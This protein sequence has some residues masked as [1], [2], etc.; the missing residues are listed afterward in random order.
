MVNLASWLALAAWGAGA[1]VVVV[2]GQ[3]LH[4]LAVKSGRLRFFGTATDTGT[5]D[6]LEYTA[7][8]NATGEFGIVVPENSM[9]WA[10]TE[11]RQGQFTLADADAV[12][13]NA[14]ANGQML[15]C[16]TLTWHSQLPEFV[17][18]GSW[19]RETL[20]AVIETHISHV[21]GH[22]KGACYS[23]DVVNEALADDGSLRDSVFSRVLGRDF[24][25]LSFRAAAA[26]DPGA[27]LYYND[28]GLE[29]GSA[30]TDGAAGI[31]RDLRAAGAR[32]DGLGF[33]AHLEVG[34]APPRRLLSAVL[35]RF[36]GMGLEVAL[37]ELDIRH[38]RVPADNDALQQQA[39]DYAGVVQACVDVDGCVG[40][41]V[42]QFTDKYSW[43]PGTF[44]GT[45]DACLYDDAMRP[46]PAYAAVA[47]VLKKAVAAAEAA[48][49]AAA[50]G[51]ANNMTKAASPP[52][53]GAQ[54]GTGADGGVSAAAVSQPPSASGAAPIGPLSGIRS[55]AAALLAS[56]A[57]AA[58]LAL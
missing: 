57:L 38:A 6:D 21:V 25:A 33:Q 20:S 27:K 41:V 44:P 9:K 43:V 15:R 55:G 37:T 31:A 34:R 17:S 23:W 4:E 14:K 53:G 48:A 3:G 42:W 56:W 8:L 19:T 39:R 29:F 49:A 7:V 51:N 46:K 16:H 58:W 13:A 32:I 22:F 18:A 35:G 30:K 26:A 54:T 10:Q 11:P 12:A 24:L 2:S 47:G 52:V 28:F 50:A 36:T 40:V 5:L 45:G 1:G